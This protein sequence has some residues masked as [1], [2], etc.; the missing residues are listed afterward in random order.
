[1]EVGTRKR[2]WHTCIRYT[3]LLIYDH[4]GEY[5]LS[6]TQRMVYGVYPPIHHWVR[7]ENIYFP[8]QFQGHRDKVKVTAATNGHSQVCAPFWHSLISI[9]VND[10]RKHIWND[11]SH[12]KVGC[13]TL[14]AYLTGSVFLH[15]Y[16]TLHCWA[17]QACCTELAWWTM[18]CFS[19]C[20]LWTV[21]PMSS[22]RTSCL[23]ISTQ[24]KYSRGILLSVVNIP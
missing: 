18:Q 20:W 10:C 12:G 5:T 11:V 19:Q 8:T 23:P 3:L 6:K 22:P 21:L 14:L 13:E 17:W 2:A 1:M 7:L 24:P 15:V 16:R 4:W 9:S